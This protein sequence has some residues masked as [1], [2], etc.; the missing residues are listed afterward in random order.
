VLRGEFITKRKTGHSEAALC[1]FSAYVHRYSRL[2]AFVT[3]RIFKDCSTSI[4]LPEIIEWRRRLREKPPAMLVFGGHKAHLCRVLRPWAATH[5]ILLALFSPHTRHLLQPLDQGFVRRLKTQ[6]SVFQQIPDFS[7]I[8]DSL[9]RIWMALQATMMTGM[10]WNSWKH[11]GMIAV[12]QNGECIRCEF[13]A[14]RVVSDPGLRT[15]LG[16]CKR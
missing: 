2:K 12:I 13:D 5:H 8:F 15:A 4:V 14:Q 10:I 3:V 7:K 1:N 16:G 6:Y 9:E 11:A